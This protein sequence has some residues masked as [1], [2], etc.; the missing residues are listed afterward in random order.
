MSI[1]GKSDEQKEQEKLAKLDL[2]QEKVREALNTLGVNFDI[3]SDEEIKEK[4]RKNILQVRAGTIQNPIADAIVIASLKSFERL[5]LMKL[6]DI[7]SQNWILIRQNE[8]LLRK[9]EKIAN[10]QGDNHPKQS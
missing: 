10:L 6:A 5:S 9:L 1:F 2:E 8:L 4:N 3:Y 7:V